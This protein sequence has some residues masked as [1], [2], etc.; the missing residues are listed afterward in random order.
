MTENLVADALTLRR[1]EDRA[2]QSERAIR[3]HV[4]ELERMLAMNRTQRRAHSYARRFRRS[5]LER[6]LADGREALR[7]KGAE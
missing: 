2:G 1:R 4:S 6:M 7:L 5:D 3:Q